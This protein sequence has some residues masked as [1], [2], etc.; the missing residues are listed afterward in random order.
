MTVSVTNN[1]VQYTG[2]GSLAIYA[3]AFRI[4]ETSDLDVYI[5]GVLQT[6]STHY[7]VSG[8]GDEGGG[9][10]TFVTPPANGV[11]ITIVRTLPLTQQTD[12]TA[13]DAFPAETH[14]EALDRL[15]Y[16]SQQHNEVFDRCLQLDPTSPITF[17]PMVIPELAADRE[18]KLLA[19]SADGTQI[20]AGEAIGTWVGDWTTATGYNKRDIM[21]DPA[22]YNVYWATEAYTSGATVAADVAGGKLDLILDANNAGVSAAAAAASAAAALASE[23]AAAADAILTA[24]DVVSTN[25][26]A[27]STAADAVSTAA[28]AVAT[29][30]DVTYAD[31]WATKAE[32]SLIS[33]AAGG[34]GSTDYSALHWAAKAEAFAPAGYTRAAIDETITG[35]WTFSGVANH[36]KQA[37]FSRATLTDGASISWN[38]DTQQ[39]AVVTL[40]G[41]RT[42]NAPTNLKEGGFYSLTIA[43]DATGGRSL[44]W[45]AVFKFTGGYA[46]TLTTF[47]NGLD[48]II[49]TSNG[50]NLYEV[51]RSMNIE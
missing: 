39:V 30:A 20:E 7:S 51:G 33:V 49:F 44:T 32:D 36:S 47:A 40:A 18:D 34:D 15:T 28:D 3:Y 22:N 11:T 14:E 43:Q 46:P 4:F 6:E 45:N 48:V 16:I 29:A 31:E 21:R 35:A 23:N 12:Y 17:P 2:N 38:A 1:R 9:N 26:D 42:M 8:A 41:N 50:T 37:Y 13:Y 5:D 25:A 10:V 24:A 27:A 19:F